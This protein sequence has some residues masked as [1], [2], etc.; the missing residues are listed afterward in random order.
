MNDHATACAAEDRAAGEYLG[1]DRRRL[2]I[3]P[4]PLGPLKLTQEVEEQR[5]APEGGLGGEE[6]L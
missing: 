1:S 3:P 4:Q 2:A 5:H 6:L